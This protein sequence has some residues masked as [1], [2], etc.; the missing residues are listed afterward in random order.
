MIDVKP[1]LRAGLIAQSGALAVDNLK[2]LNKKKTTAKDFIKSGT[3]NI[4]G[5]EFIR[6]QG[7]LIES[8]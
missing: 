8:L 7:G 5:T 4:L 3:K 1:I 6:I 2:L